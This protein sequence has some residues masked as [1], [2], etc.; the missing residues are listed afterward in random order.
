ME[1]TAIFEEGTI[2]DK[3]VFNS[4]HLVVVTL[5]ELERQ[6]FVTVYNENDDNKIRVMNGG[7]INA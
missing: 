3:V 1:L 5:W 7:V 2:I 6:L 4:P